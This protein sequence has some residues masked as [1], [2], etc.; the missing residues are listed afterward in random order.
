MLLKGLCI[1][2]EYGI[3]IEISSETVAV[4]K[5]AIMITDCSGCSASNSHSGNRFHSLLH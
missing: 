2:F 1:P 4:S 3:T 5:K